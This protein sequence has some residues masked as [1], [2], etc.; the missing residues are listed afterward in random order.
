MLLTCRRCAIIV[1]KL[2]A[3]EQ[4]GAR[5]RNAMTASSSS[6]RSRRKAGAI[7]WNA[8]PMALYGGMKSYSFRNIGYS[9]R[10]YL[11]KGGNSLAVPMHALREP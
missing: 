2:P 5:S 6:T 8:A 7:L 9:M 10:I 4:E 3:S 1:M 11:I